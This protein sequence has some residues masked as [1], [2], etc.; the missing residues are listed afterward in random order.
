M[1]DSLPTT[2]ELELKRVLPPRDAGKYIG[3]SP[4]TLANWRVSGKGPRFIRLSPRKIVYRVA[5]LELWLGER[6]FGSTTEADQ[7]K[8]AG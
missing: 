7:H 8:V 2:S 3:I 6:V 1:R 4:L 5:D